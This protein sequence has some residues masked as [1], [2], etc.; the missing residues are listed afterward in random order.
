[1]VHYAADG[2]EFYVLKPR[3]TGSLFEA[4]TI[5]FA[6]ALPVSIVLRDSLGQHTA[7]ELADVSPNQQVDAAVY[8]FIT[9]PGV[10]VIDDR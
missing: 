2:H 7:I 10:D 5:E 4:L 6:E 9:P 1:M 8:T 3:D